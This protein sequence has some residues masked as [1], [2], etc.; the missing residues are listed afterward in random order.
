MFFHTSLY[1]VSLHFTVIR[2]FYTPARV[3]MGR[4][5]GETGA[6]PTFCGLA[7]LGLPLVFHN[8]VPGPLSPGGVAPV[9]FILAGRLGFR[10]L[11]WHEMESCFPL[12]R[13]A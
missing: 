9:S 11:R 1:S 6:T 5:R 7:R 8:G 2:L 13:G 10:R 12:L 4:E 3:P